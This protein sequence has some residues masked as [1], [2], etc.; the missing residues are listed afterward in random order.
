MGRLLPRLID[1]TGFGLFVAMSLPCWDNY[2]GR[3]L[4]VVV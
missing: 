4:G 2:G 3:G 1:A